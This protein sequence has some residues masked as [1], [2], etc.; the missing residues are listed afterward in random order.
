MLVNEFHRPMSFAIRFSIFLYIFSLVSCS[1]PDKFFCVVSGFGNAP[2]EKTY[3]I[4]PFIPGLENNLEFIEYAN[5]LKRN[6][7]A[8]GYKEKRPD[9]AALCVKFGYYI[10][11]N[12]LRGSVESSN[13]EGG[14]VT[15][16]TYNPIL[17]TTNINTVSYGKTTSSSQAIY[18]KP[19]GVEI[20]VIDIKKSKPV[21]MVTVKDEIDGSLNG[22]SFRKVMP[23]LMVCSQNYYEKNGESK[24]EI[25]RTVGEMQMGLIWPY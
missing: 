11:E 14:G 17:Q 15:Y 10:G 9:K 5:L 1:T 12:T 20:E 24:V 23:W 13:T 19:I 21:W 4:E 18:K 8:K 6:L 16:S 2:E 25:L 22:A 7:N 3:Y